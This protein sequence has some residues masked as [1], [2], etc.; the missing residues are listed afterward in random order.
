MKFDFGSNFVNFL[1]F[2]RR[3]PKFPENFNLADHAGAR[4]AFEKS[5]V[6]SRFLEDVPDERVASKGGV[7]GFVRRRLGLPLI[8]A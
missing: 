5:R 3:A 6:A 7:P 4:A 2:Y 1:S 8:R